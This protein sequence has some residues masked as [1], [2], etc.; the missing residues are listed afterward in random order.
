MMMF[1]TLLAAVFA[2]IYGL[3]TVLQPKLPLFYKIVTY[4]FGSYLIGTLYGFLYTELL[5]GQK[6]FHAGYLGY[7]GT[8][9]FLF[10]S[11]FGA[12]DRLADGHE[13][14]YRVYRLTALLPAA[15][16]LLMGMKLLRQSED[17]FLFFL[18]L[19][20][21]GTAYFACKHL[22]LPDVEM[23]IIRVMR[24]YNTIIMLWCLLQPLMLGMTGEG[25]GEWILTGANALLVMLA[26]PV[27]RK[28]VRLWFT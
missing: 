1:I 6:G 16:V 22:I 15:A 10:S 8:Y 3:S 18:L 19:P 13:R 28:G 12:L 14:K 26:L 20:A 5:Y 4:G 24:P 9:F 17:I 21:A 2:G 11:Y 27:A 23:G 25:A 7:V